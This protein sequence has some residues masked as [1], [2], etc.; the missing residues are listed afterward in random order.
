MKK[1]KIL[2]IT[3]GYISRGGVETFL[4]NWISQASSEYEFTWYYPHRCVDESCAYEFRKKGISLICGGMDYY[5]KNIVYKIKKHFKISGDIKELLKH[6]SFAAVHVNTGSVIINSIALKQAKKNNIRN[7]I[8]HSHSSDELIAPTFKKMVFDALRRSVNNNVTKRAACSLVAAESLFGKKY[9]NDTLIINNGVDVNKFSFSE[10]KRN[11][12][13]EKYNLNQC[14]VIGETGMLC[15]DKNQVFL[16]DIFKQI[17]EKDN[18]CR[19][20]LVGTGPDEGIIKQHVQKLGLQNVVIFVGQTFEPEKFYNAMDVFV[21]PSNREGLSFALIEAQTSGLP[22]IVSTG[23]SKEG[24]LT[25]KCKFISLNDSAETWVD[26]ILSYKTTDVKS[27]YNVAK[28]IEEKNYDLAHYKT[29][30]EKLY[31]E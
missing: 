31:E 12:C 2:L 16:V 4:E 15:K 29:L 1:K 5:N 27:R 11:S 6:G 17:Y 18:E 3:A 22:C 26:E 21:L 7:R 25:G 20:M 10:E 8:G 13:R 24:D 14:F 23:N 19:L 28:I 9:I 30:A